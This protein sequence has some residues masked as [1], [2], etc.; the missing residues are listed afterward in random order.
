MKIENTLENKAKFFAQYWGQK[1][2]CYNSEGPIINTF[3]KN[4]VCGRFF[5]IGFL[6]LTPLS[7]ITDEDAIEVAKILFGKKF[8]LGEVLRTTKYISVKVL[9]EN[10]TIN[11]NVRITYADCHLQN[12]NGY[13]LSNCIDAFDYLR[14]KGYVLPWMGLSVEELV[15]YGWVKL[16][17]EMK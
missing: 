2:F 15:E 6:E 10:T 3:H 7:Q 11:Q 12:A 1:V 8:T 4:I 9:V 17:E 5:S 14:S 16:K 13:G